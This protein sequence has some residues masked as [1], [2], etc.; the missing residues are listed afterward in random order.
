MIKRTVKVQVFVVSIH[1]NQDKPLSPA[2]PARTKP[3]PPA[4]ELV[5]RHEQRHLGQVPAQQRVPLQLAHLHLGL[6]RGGAADGRHQQQRPGLAARAL[7]AEVAPPTAA[8]EAEAQ[9]VAE[10]ARRR[11]PKEHARGGHVGHHGQEVE[12][13]GVWRLSA[14][15]VSQQAGVP[16]TAPEE[17]HAGGQWLV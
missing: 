6:Q 2:H 3:R 17:T 13:D 9:R 12:G 10:H 16:L 14:G 4:L 1:S 5:R 15:G 7:H 11:D 8:R